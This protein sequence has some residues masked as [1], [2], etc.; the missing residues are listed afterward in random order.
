MAFSFANRVAKGATRGRLM[1]HAAKRA[2]IIFAI[3]LF[4]AGAGYAVSFSQLRYPGVLQRIA[5][6]Y[7]IASV[8][9]LF[10]GRR[11]W[12]ITTAVLLIGY[13]ATM[14]YVPV[15]G[16]G[17]VPIQLVSSED[18]V[19][20][21]QNDNLAAYVDRAVVPG[22][23]YQKTWDPEGVLSTF[24]AIG[25]ALI[26]LLVGDWMRRQQGGMRVVR[27][28]AL[29]GAALMIVGRALHPIAPI[30]KNLW[31]STYV[32]F[33]AGF[34]MLLLALSYWAVDIRKWRGPGATFC[35]VFGMNSILVYA[36]SSFVGHLSLL[37]HVGD[38]ANRLTVKG[39]LYA[40]SFAHVSNPYV[41]SMAWGM[42]YVA[43]WWAVMYVF[44]KRQIFVKV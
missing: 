40:H 28:L 44:Y 43:L 15:P 39:W 36:L 6:C 11:T 32:L 1:A 37:L 17:R 42:A 10:S 23:L 31:T 34:A 2:A 24:P 8:F 14:N 41:G 3:G 13:W 21:Q 16:H 35:L 4:L 18:Q 29:V 27:T 7:L 33:T 25:T 5:V 20:A 26:G 19:K 9:A 38:A 22:T 30:N 12:L